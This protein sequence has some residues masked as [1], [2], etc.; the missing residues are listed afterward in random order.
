MPSDVRMTVRLGQCSALRCGPLTSRNPEMILT[1]APPS[2][3]IQ[4]SP[5]TNP[6][7]TALPPK[8][9]Q[10]VAEVR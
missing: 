5:T 8:L 3:Q 10:N 7:V 1:S 6:Q 9:I 4:Q 2:A